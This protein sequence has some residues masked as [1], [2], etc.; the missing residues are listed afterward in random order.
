MFPPSPKTVDS[1]ATADYTMVTKGLQ[2]AEQSGMNDQNNSIC[3]ARHL[4]HVCIAVRDIEETLGFYD[5]VFGIGPT[6]V[7]EIEDQGV[8]AALVRVGET[9]LEFMEPT[10]DTGSVARFVEKRGDAMHHI[11]FEVNDLAAT[12]QRLDAN[13][14]ELVDKSPRQGLSGMIAFIH[15][16]S[17]RGVLIELVDRES[18]RS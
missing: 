3:T 4:N 13:G 15:P 6:E 17:T 8:R 12:L 1:A 10:D 7:K 18:A 9:Q 5:K 2:P 14:V 11:C 16:R